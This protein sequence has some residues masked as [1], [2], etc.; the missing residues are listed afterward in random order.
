VTAAVVAVLFS[1]IVENYVENVY[2]IHLK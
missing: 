1:T 2:N